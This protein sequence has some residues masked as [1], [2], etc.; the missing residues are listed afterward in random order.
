M[1]D[2]HPQWRRFAWFEALR[3][4]EGAGQLSIAV[5][6][7][8]YSRPLGA[9]HGAHQGGC[10]A[11]VSVSKEALFHGLSVRDSGV[12]LNVIGAASVLDDQDPSLA[13]QS[14]VIGGLPDGD[15]D[16]VL[17][18]FRVRARNYPHQWSA[19]RR[20][21]KGGRLSVRVGA[22]NCADGMSFRV[23]VRV[24]IR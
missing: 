6:L 7:P 1:R 21:R 17:K 9:R 19:F 14:G 2:I 22:V 10:S 11:A 5:R 12:N 3:S 16:V 23:M 24:V 13:G 18:G 4:F 8:V 15:G 20:G